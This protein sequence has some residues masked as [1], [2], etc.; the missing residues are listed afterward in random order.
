MIIFANAHCAYYCKSHPCY[1][2]V[3]K[4]LL[5]GSSKFRCEY[6]EIKT[7]YGREEIYQEFEL[8]NQ[9]YEGYEWFKWVPRRKSKIK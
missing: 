5:E 4:K 3:S 2:S 7:K 1:Q 6:N 8:S 9:I